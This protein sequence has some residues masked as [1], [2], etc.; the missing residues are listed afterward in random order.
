MAPHTPVLWLPVDIHALQQRLVSESAARSFVAFRN[1]F[2][3]HRV[4]ARRFALGFVSLR[5]LLCNVCM[6]VCMYVCIYILF[7]YVCI[8]T[9]MH[10]CVPAALWPFGTILVLI[11]SKSAASPLPSSVCVCCYV[12]YVYIYIYG[13]SPLAW[14][15][16]V[17]CYVMY[18]YIYI[19]IYMVL[20]LWLGQS[21]CVVM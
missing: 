20:R 11:V 19:Y 18:I 14:S 12:M 4:E 10:V 15:V 21:A 9:N 6:Y 13:A 2:C 8:H 3:A 17:C 5:V 1:H 16:C 7:A